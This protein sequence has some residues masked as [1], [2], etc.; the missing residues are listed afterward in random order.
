MHELSYIS[1][2][3]S[4]HDS[5]SAHSTRAFYY[6]LLCSSGG[7]LLRGKVNGNQHYFKQL[8]RIYVLGWFHVCALILV[9]LI[10]WQHWNSYL[11]CE[12]DKPRPTSWI[13]H[14]KSW[15]LSS[16]CLFVCFRC[17]L[18]TNKTAWRATSTLESPYPSLSPS[19]PS[20]SCHSVRKEPTSVRM[21]TAT[22]I[23]PSTP[24]D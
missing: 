2:L 21:P 10:R 20:F 15:V 5:P 3:A 16:Q 11:F 6:F 23:T 19:S 13:L 12:M 17:C 1:G 8:T 24:H 9:L 4:V 7:P 14:T 22:C 18:S